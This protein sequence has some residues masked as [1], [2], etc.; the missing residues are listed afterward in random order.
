MIRKNA[1]I[2]IG[3]MIPVEK[4]KTKEMARLIVV[5]ATEAIPPIDERYL[6]DAM[7]SVILVNDDHFMVPYFGGRLSFDVLMTKPDGPV[8]VNTSTIFKIQNLQIKKEDDKCP[9]CGKT[10]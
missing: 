2:K 4:Q 7:E 10:L 9:T 6:T 1:G 3:E 8:I 5:E